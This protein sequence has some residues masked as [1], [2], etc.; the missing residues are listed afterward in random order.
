ML[1]KLIQ[2][3]KYGS[4][5]RNTPLPREVSWFS[6]KVKEKDSRVTPD[7][8]LSKEEFEAIVKATENP[9]DRALV[10]VIFEAALRPGELLTMTVGNVN[11][12]DNYCLITVNGKIG[13]KRIPL[14]VSYKPLLEWLSNH[15][16]KG[17]SRSASLVLACNIITRERG[18]LTGISDF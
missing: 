1:R 12:K 16:Q 8:L 7:S 14:V 6:L 17:R 15:P 4:C 2:Y 18:S 5:D 11:F 10:Y 13:I 3:A 9:R